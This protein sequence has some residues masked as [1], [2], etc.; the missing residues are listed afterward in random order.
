MITKENRD[1]ALHELRQ[2]QLD[3]IEDT[4]KEYCLIELASTNT[5]TWV[6]IELSN[7][8]YDLQEQ[9][10]NGGLI[11]EVYELRELIE[12]LNVNGLY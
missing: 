3:I 10:V 4:D 8:L 5:M 2:E 12:E 6:D 11:L 1:Y 9:N 7:D